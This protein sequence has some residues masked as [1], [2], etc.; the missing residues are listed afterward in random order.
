MDWS[1]VK[2]EPRNGV[3]SLVVDDVRMRGLGVAFD[4]NPETDE[5]HPRDA[6]H[7]LIVDCD[8]PR[9]ANKDARESLAATAVI[10]HFGESE[11]ATTALSDPG[12]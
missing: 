6:A 11:A 4:P 12:E 8:M 9:R 5:P 1:D 10:V 2:R 3:F 7:T